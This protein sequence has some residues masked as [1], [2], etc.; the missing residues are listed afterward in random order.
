MNAIIDILRYLK[1]TPR[2]K[3]LFTKYAHCQR[4]NAYYYDYWTK[5]VPYTLNLV[6]QFKYN[7]RRQH[8][9]VI[10]H[11]LRY[12]KASTRNKTLFTKNKYCQ[13]ICL[14]L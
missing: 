12:L 9:N 6:S 10:I 8:M 4:I 7:S 3:F 2:N 11:I 5:V 13:N 1:V 14:Y